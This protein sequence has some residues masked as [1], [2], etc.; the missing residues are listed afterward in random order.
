MSTLALDASPDVVVSYRV[1]YWQQFPLPILAGPLS[2]SRWLPASGGKIVRLICGTYEQAQS[3]LFHQHVTAE[4]T[5]FDLGANVG[6]YTLLAAKL[7]RLGQV[8]AFEPEPRN[9]AFLRSNIAANRCQNVSIHELAIAAT[10]G[11]A[12][13]KFGSGS[14]TGALAAEGT[15]AVKTVKLDEFVATSGLRPTHLK[16]DVEGAEIDVLRGGLEALQ[17]C[18]P[19][20]FLS[21]HG[22]AAHADCCEL[23]QELKYDLQ[24]IDGPDVASAA[25]LLCLG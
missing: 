16:I 17:A 24:P 11:V 23:L 13:F 4:S 6:Y 18:R 2:G 22:A 7:A 3:R 20:I 25:E 12:K 10:T 21:T 19:T 1:P 5:V 15:L 14:G 8:V 9:A